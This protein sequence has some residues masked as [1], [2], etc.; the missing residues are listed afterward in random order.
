MENR[1]SNG[2]SDSGLSGIYA[3][4]LAA[5]WGDPEKVVNAAINEA[6]R[7]GA[8]LDHDD[9]VS[10]AKKVGILAGATHALGTT[11]EAFTQQFV[12]DIL[13]GYLE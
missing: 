13:A 10:L 6:F 2:D 4:Q 12:H 7:A 3:E 8:E 11:P 9:Q 1:L 5:S